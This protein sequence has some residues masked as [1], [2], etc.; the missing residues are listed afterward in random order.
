MDPRNRPLLDD[1]RR[2]ERIPLHVPG[3]LHL[4]A[5]VCVEVVVQNV[6]EN[7][8]LLSTLDLEHTVERQDR[9]VVELP[10]VPMPNARIRVGGVVRVDL[11]MTDE[12]IA[13]QVAICFD[14]GPRPVGVA[15]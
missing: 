12:G 13:R 8:V 2:F 5:G 6:G 15:L 1:R 14:G 9:V 7:G 3:R 4:G 10:D 11:E